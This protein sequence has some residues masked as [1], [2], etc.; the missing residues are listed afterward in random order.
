MRFNIAKMISSAKYYMGCS[1]A[2]K[3][4]NKIRFFP[5]VIENRL[6]TKQEI[7]A[8]LERC[9]FQDQRILKVSEEGGDSVY[10][11]EEV[12]TFLN[13]C[14]IFGNVR[15]VEISLNLL[16]HRYLDFQAPTLDNY[17]FLD[18]AVLANDDRLL[19]VDLTLEAAHAD[20]ANYDAVALF[21]AGL[22]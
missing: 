6:Y 4:I 14:N 21:G 7:F 15:S 5:E 18:R 11:A 19:T 9:N 22:L 20:E 1:R 17:C 3:P 2:F 13:G 8:L 10:A 12:V 16:G